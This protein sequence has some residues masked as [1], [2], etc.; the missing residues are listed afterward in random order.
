MSTDK[1]GELRERKEKI[2]QGGDPKAID[3]L[4]GEGKLTAR[5]RID[6]LFDPGS[7]IELDMFAKHQSTFFGM[8]NRV[9]PAD[10]IIAGYG[11]IEGRT[12]FAYAQDFTVLRGTFGEM[13]GRKIAKVMDMAADVG[14]PI[15]GLCH[16][17]GL[18]LHEILGPMQPF[19]HLFYR[20]SIYS[21]VVPQISAVMGSIAGG[22]AYSSGLTDFIFMTKDSSMY[23]AAPNFVETVT[24]EKV[25]EAEL[26]GASMHARISGAC[27]VVTEDDKD[28]LLRIR[29]LLSYLPSSS[30]DKPPFV[31]TGD[32]PNRKDEE[33][34]QI[35]PEKSNQSYDMKGILSRVVDNGKLFEIHAQ[36]AANMIVTFARLGGHSVGIIANQPMV[37]AGGIDVWAAEKAAR[38]IRF[39]DA[40]N[41]PIVY[42]VDT[43]AYHVG[44]YQERLGIIYRGATLLYATSE[45]TVPKLTVFIRKAYAGAYIAMGSKYLGA[46]QALAWPTAEI[47]TTA[48]ET[49]GNVIFR[50]EIEAARNPEEVR[51][52]RF[53]EFSDNFVNAY[54]AAEIQHID[55]VIEPWE[56]RPRL[57]N[58]LE[59]LQNKQRKL[60]PK[61]HGNTPF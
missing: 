3:K 15:I 27:H 12:V 6:F 53:Q 50:S 55:D 23:I 24:G 54:Y 16:T 13:H 46:D 5:E 17:G 9:I 43:P 7:F 40:F 21:G 48:P 41:I 2:R 18:R 37:A 35:L 1:L 59:M 22:Q 8:E 39:C 30:R 42:F 10:G 32:D 29:E 51:Q 26:G 47:C 49:T 44:T 33:L 19:G 20:N 34:N 38:F 14:A 36:W 56:T 25:T 4:H 58:A 45:A 28:C 11:K 52:Q 31:D 60:P 57:V 61:K